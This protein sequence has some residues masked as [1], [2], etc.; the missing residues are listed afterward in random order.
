MVEREQVEIAELGDR[1]QRDIAKESG[2]VKA[3]IDGSDAR[4]EQLLKEKEEFYERRRATWSNWS[5][6]K[7]PTN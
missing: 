1:Y 2:R 3:E 5:K 4:I 7:T 6:P